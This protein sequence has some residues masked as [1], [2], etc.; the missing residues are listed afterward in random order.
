MFHLDLCTKPNTF[1]YEFSNFKTVC[2]LK[3]SQLFVYISCCF[4]R[5]CVNLLKASVKPLA[6]LCACAYEYVYEI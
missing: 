6:R 1:Y 2:P 3:K 5:F 4:C